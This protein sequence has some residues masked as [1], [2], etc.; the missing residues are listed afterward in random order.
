MRKHFCYDQNRSAKERNSSS[1]TDA[2]EYRG[3]RQQPAVH[4][5]NGVKLCLGAVGLSSLGG[6]S[7]EPRKTGE[8][9]R[10]KGSI[11]RTFIAGTVFLA[12]VAALAHFLPNA[13]VTARAYAA[14]AEVPGID[15]LWYAANFLK[16]GSRTPRAAVLE[17]YWAVGRHQGLPGHVYVS[18]RTVPRNGMLEHAWERAFGAMWNAR[19]AIRGVNYALP[20]EPR[21]PY[22]IQ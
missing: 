8:G 5:Q 17:H 6:G 20:P 7:I 18:A 15:T 10:E 21:R 12:R 2:L 11:D 9:V 22:R 13:T 3:R 4:K 14:L 19:G 1:R 16:N